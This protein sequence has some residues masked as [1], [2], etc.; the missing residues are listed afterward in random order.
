M[1]RALR[2]LRVCVRMCAVRAG[3]LFTSVRTSAAGVRENVCA[4]NARA[5]RAARAASAARLARRT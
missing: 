2:V 3:L 5:A 1:L 4:R